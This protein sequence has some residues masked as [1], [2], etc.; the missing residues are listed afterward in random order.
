MSESI[1]DSHETGSTADTGQTIATDTMGTTITVGKIPY[2]EIHQNGLTFLPQLPS[3]KFKHSAWHDLRQTELHGT[4]LHAP[5]VRRGPPEKEKYFYKLEEEGT[6]IHHSLYGIAR[7]NH[8]IELEQ[9]EYA[10]AINLSFQELAHNYQRTNF[11][12]ILG[13]LNSAVTVNLMNNKLTHLRQYTFPQCESLNLNQN[14]ITTFWQLPRTPKIR[15]L[16]LA[17]NDVYTFSCM[18]RLVST[19][20]QELTLKGNPVSFMLNYRQ[21]VFRLIPNLRILDGIPKLPSDEGFY[22]VDNKKTCSII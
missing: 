20:I 10:K 18:D 9:W 3:H 17:N 8:M 5:R 12:R 11:H 7:Q 14:Y 19:P 21:K 22:E 4:E 6:P 15:C 13:R 1:A 16:T 2:H